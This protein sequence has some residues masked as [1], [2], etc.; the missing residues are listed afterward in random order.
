MVC[1]A[2]NAPDALISQVRADRVFRVVEAVI[3]L[4]H[5]GKKNNTESLF[6]CKFVDSLTAILDSILDVAP[7]IRCVIP[8]KVDNR[9]FRR[10]I[11]FGAQL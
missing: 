6:K 11:V 10:H 4:H 5:F 1:A 3:E 2:E 9:L 7:N 8:V